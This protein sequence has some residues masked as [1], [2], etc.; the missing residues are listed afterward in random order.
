MSKT[1]TA[2]GRCCS[3]SENTGKLIFSNFLYI[4]GLYIHNFVFW[5][6][7][8]RME[9]VKSFVCNQPY[10]MASCL[11]MFTNLSASII[12]IARVEMRF[13]EKYKLYS[14]A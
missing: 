2:T 11:A 14:E 5:I 7:D 10:D 6:T 1:V 3:I 4:L 9:L 13:H 12:F 8:M